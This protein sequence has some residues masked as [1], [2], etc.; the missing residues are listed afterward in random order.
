MKTK[1]KSIKAFGVLAVCGTLIFAI[2]LSLSGGT[3][4]ALT[5][6]P[7]IEDILSSVSGA[8]SYDILEIVPEEG[9][10]T[11]GYYVAGQEPSIGYAL[12]GLTAPG[13]RS[14][15]ANKI[16]GYLRSLGILGSDTVTPLTSL[17]SGGF[18]NERTPWDMTPADYA[19]MTALQL[20]APETRT[21]NGSFAAAV[22]G[23]Y[24]KV[25]K[26]ATGG[27]DHV[28]VIDRFEYSTAG[29]EGRYYYSPAFVKL[30]GFALP[31]TPT[32]IYANTANDC[33]DDLGAPKPDEKDI[34]PSAAGYYYVGTSGSPDL[35][36]DKAV[37]YYTVSATGAPSAAWDASHPYAAISDDFA[38]V[39]TGTGY[40]SLMHYKYVG[41]GMGH[42]SFT[43]GGSESVT[44]EY[45][46]I[47]FKLGYTNNNWF[48]THVFDWDVGEKAPN[49][50]VKT[51]AAS[52]VSVQDVRDAELIFLSGG[53]NLADGKSLANKYTGV[54]DIS[55]EVST[56]I[57]A[58]NKD[59]RPI[60]VDYSC[61]GKTTN[62][63]RLAS[64]LA[65]KSGNYVANNI[66]CFTPPLKTN[67]GDISAF[68]TKY[69]HTP[70]AAT[71]D[72][73]E[74]LNEIR[75]ENFLRKNENDKT[76]DLLPEEV[77]L[78]NS[79]RYI[80]N[81]AGK[82]S[83]G[84]KESI[85]VLELQPSTDKSAINEQVVRG[86]LGD[87][88]P[89]NIKIV[90]MPVAEF[91]GKI[92]DLTETYDLIY[93]GASLGGLN[94]N[95]KTTQYND[96]YMNGLLYCNIGDKYVSNSQLIGMLDRDYQTTGQKNTFKSGSNT[97]YKAVADEKNR[98]FR[99]SGN[100]LTPAKEAELA[101]FAK[102]G[103]PIVLD[104]AL[105]TNSTTLKEV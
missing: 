23:D 82:R 76:K 25:M 11:I 6:L 61:A 62:I 55:T 98:T 103:Y 78:A 63:G 69:F 43:Q 19:D 39:A 101:A 29:V 94:N 57:I 14:E 88:A 47:W 105:C 59:L 28:Q 54:V 4:L 9:S 46:R 66:L 68:A 51:L 3:A 1:K 85:T 52:A 32:A 13:A 71:A 104:E 44:I 16:Q 93:I 65:S 83:V 79:I 41:A 2:F 36:L 73:A 45:N 31:S 40:F 87:G 17:P 99:F 86:W 90:T 48:R 56:A 37:T 49:I 12:A 89:K 33:V 81:Y 80:I 20:S 70:F 21:A 35:A 15:Y 58:A 42:Y 50:R 92:D 75:N 96:S 91:I 100:D 24:D 67:S 38:A 60:I 77:T 84:S 7:H 53:I 30:D 5:S 8:G 64:A 74:V 97:Y 34:A 72:F 22:G 102:S 27:G 18:Y 26:I 95:G 10:G